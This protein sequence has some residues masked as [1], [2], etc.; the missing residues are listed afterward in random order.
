[1]V[2]IGCPE[3]T[4]RTFWPEHFKNR[5]T[6]NPIPKFWFNVY[7]D[8][9][10]LSSDFKGTL[11]SRHPKLLHHGGKQKLNGL[12]VL[13]LQGMAAHTKYWS[14]GNGSSDLGCW[15]PVVRSMREVGELRF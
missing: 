11:L 8:T 1:L 15:V 13:L 10:V 12:E 6:S 7:S 4:V 3:K 9:D 2:T 5:D 14:K